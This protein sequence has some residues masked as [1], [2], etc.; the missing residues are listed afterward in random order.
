MYERM[1]TKQHL[2]NET[3]I[4]EYLGAAA[5][6]RMMKLEAILANEYDFKKEMRFPFGNHYGWGMKYNHKTMHLCYAF[7]EKGAFTVMIQIG[8]R[9]I[10]ELS[11]RMNE[12]SKKAKQLWADRYPCGDTGGW[13]NIRILA[14]CD[15]QD[16]LCFIHAK[17]KPSSVSVS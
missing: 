16:A 2:P 13:V 9:Q 1:L 7:F 3:E 6:A 4:K 8:D 12:L 5:W 10:A 17:K 14:D 11:K 15:L